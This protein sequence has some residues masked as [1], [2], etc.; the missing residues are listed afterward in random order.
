M[1][2]EQL[3]DHVEDHTKELLDWVFNDIR[4]SLNAPLSVF[5]LSNGISETGVIRIFPDDPLQQLGPLCKEI[6]KNKR[7]A[8]ECDQDLIRRLK[9]PQTP[10]EY[11]CHCGF[12]SVQWPIRVEGKHVGTVLCGQRLLSDTLD[13][14]KR[15]FAEFLHRHK[16]IIPRKELL[17]QK[18]DQSPVV[19]RADFNKLHDELKG[20]A[21]LMARL[22]FDRKRIDGQREHYEKVVRRISHELQNYTQAALG[23]TGEL[24]HRLQKGDLEMSRAVGR[25]LKGTLVHMVTMARN[26]M[27]S[28]TQNTPFSEIDLLETVRKCARIYQWFAAN[29]G[30]AIK[31][32]SDGEKAFIMGST[33]HIEQVIANLLHN[34]IKYSKGDCVDIHTEVVDQ[35]SIKVSF[36]NL[37]IGI[38]ENEYGRIF[39]EPYRGIAAGRWDRLGMGL[40]LHIVK[41]IVDMHNGSVKVENNPLTDDIHQTVFTVVLPCKEYRK[42]I[43]YRNQKTPPGRHYGN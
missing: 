33:F 1:D 37:G 3:S 13:V 14:S 6:Y 27:W 24:R 43:N 38:S 23:A 10:G 9:G 42:Q 16:E 35:K 25:D 36:T 15:M 11:L 26:V 41:G 31:V 32:H 19:R 12:P 8:R 2:I 28:P 29:K 4:E 22:Y 34:A 5:Q 17:Q 30:M 7:L 21:N 40:G 39:E 20:T 18:F